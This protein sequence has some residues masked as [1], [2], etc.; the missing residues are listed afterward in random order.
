M[1]KNLFKKL[2]AAT[3]VGVMT[4]G[5]MGCNKKESDT[6]A[7]STL[8]KVKESKKLVIGTSADYPPYEF[9]KEI[10]GKDEIVGFDILIAEELAKDLGV[11]IKLSDMSF[12]GLLAALKT[13]KVDMVISGMNPSEERKKS[14]DFSDIYYKA[15]HGIIVRAEDKDKYPDLDSLTGK[16]VGVQKGSIQQ[17]IATSQIKD[18][19]FKGL[20]KVTDL[21]MELKNNKVDAVVTELP[22][23]EFYT[24]RNPDLAMT[25]CEFE[26]EEDLGTAIAVKKGEVDFIEEINKTLNR[27]IK[28]GKISEFMVEANKMVE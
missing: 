22:V 11:E 1:K 7:V 25:T 19:D 12:D 14:V 26:A 3:M 18:A 23:G 13:G 15:Q 4:F 16:K 6:G 9:H 21:M 24:E 20:S 28:E 8:E 5:L 2:I 17:Q 10:N 27:L